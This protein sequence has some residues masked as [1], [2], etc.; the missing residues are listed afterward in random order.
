MRLFTENRA[1]REKRES[2][3]FAKECSK[4]NVQSFSIIKGE[5]KEGGGIASEGTIRI[6]AFK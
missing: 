3:K 1:I 2:V 5:K 4:I 6:N